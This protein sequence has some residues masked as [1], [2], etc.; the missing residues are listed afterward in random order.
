MVLWDIVTV[1][2]L[3][4]GL[5]YGIWK[6]FLRLL[7]KAGA[8]FL[9]IVLARPVGNI[10]SAKFVDG[11]FAGNPFEEILQSVASIVV[12]IVIFVVLYILLKLLAKLIA[13][14]VNKLFDSKKIDKVLGA[15]VGLV[16]GCGMMFLIATAVE[17]A[18]AVVTSLDI[19]VDW[20]DFGETFLFR[21]FL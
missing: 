2:V 5:L 20:L 14:A 15:I 18:N 12:S 11:M 1:V 8:L 16:I 4:L 21:F 7:L 3:G 13:S 19:S 6:G 10:V 9:A 17:F